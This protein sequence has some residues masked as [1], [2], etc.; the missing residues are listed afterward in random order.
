MD[1]GFEDDEIRGFL[2]ENFKRVATTTWE[3][4]P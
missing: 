2:G 4:T 1:Y 3:I